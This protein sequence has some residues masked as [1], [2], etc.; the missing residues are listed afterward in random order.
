MAGQDELC[1]TLGTA[2]DDETKEGQ[3][4]LVQAAQPDKLPIAGAALNSKTAASGHEQRATANGAAGAADR[5]AAERSGLV[6]VP[7]EMV[8]GWCMAPSS[9]A[10]SGVADACCRACVRE[11][12]R[13]C[14]SAYAYKCSYACLCGHAP[15]HIKQTQLE[16]LCLQLPLARKLREIEGE[17]GHPPCDHISEDDAEFAEEEMDMSEEEDVWAS[18]VPRREQIEPRVRFTGTDINRDIDR[19][20][21]AEMVLGRGR[22][23]RGERPKD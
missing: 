19:D 8:S 23:G 3:G 22:R 5:D 7:A 18:S 12:V 6:T 9:C 13:M 21:E 2:G 10:R 17:A 1:S 14:V 4:I 15:M 16:L 11:R 20:R